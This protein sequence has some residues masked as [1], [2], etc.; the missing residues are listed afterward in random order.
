[1]FPIQDHPL[2]N[3]GLGSCLTLEGFVETDAA[4]MDGN[5]CFSGAVGAMKG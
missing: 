3:A 1:M 2:T 5:S 4:I